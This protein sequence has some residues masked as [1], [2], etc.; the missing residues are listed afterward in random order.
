MPSGHRVVP[1]TVEGGQSSGSGSAFL[2]DDR[3]GMPGCAGRLCRGRGMAAQEGAASCGQGDALE[4]A[5]FVLVQGA[6]PT[7]Q[8]VPAW[9]WSAGW[10]GRTGHGAGGTIGGVGRPVRVPGRKGLGLAGHTVPF[11]GS[12]TVSR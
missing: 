4:L 11:G 8:G 6:H 1:V 7:R 10:S 5:L 2:V 12:D 3:E 9:P